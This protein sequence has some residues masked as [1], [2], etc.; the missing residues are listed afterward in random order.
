[1]R[2][3]LMLADRLS[4]RLEQTV[5]VQAVAVCLQDCECKTKTLQKEAGISSAHYHAGMSAGA[6]VKVQ[7][8]WR[9]GAVQVRQG[10]A[11]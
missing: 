1:M 2:P 6:R 8:A 7:N 10:L 4:G 5:H 3:L 11:V 9:S